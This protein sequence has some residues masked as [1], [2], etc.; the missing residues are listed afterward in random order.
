MQ[1]ERHRRHA[2][3]DAPPPRA[4]EI[5]RAA[6][7]MAHVDVGRGDRP[8]VLEQEGQVGSERGQQRA[9]KAHP[10]AIVDPF[11]FV[12]RDRRVSGLTSSLEAERA[13]GG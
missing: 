11:L 1:R 12:A 3:T 2:P 13:V 5:D 4:E 8:S 6:R 9:D 7:R 10:L